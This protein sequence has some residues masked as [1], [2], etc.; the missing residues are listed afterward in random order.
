MSQVSDLDVSVDFMKKVAM[1]RC[2]SGSSSSSSGGDNE[3][4]VRYV[5][6]DCIIRHG[7]EDQITPYVQPDNYHAW[8]ENLWLSGAAVEN[9]R[10][11]WTLR[12]FNAQRA[13]DARHEARKLFAL[14]YDKWRIFSAN[15][16]AEQ[17]R[18]TFAV[19][20]WKPFVSTRIIYGACE[21]RNKQKAQRST[22]QRVATEPS[23]GESASLRWQ[24]GFCAHADCLSA[25]IESRGLCKNHYH[26][27]FNRVERPAKRRRKA[28]ARS[29]AKT[30]NVHLLQTQFGI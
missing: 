19:P 28:D 10:N 30:E 16:K 27:T 6:G 3:R 23:S 20:E 11:V 4:I 15:R 1:L 2:G 22:W 12:E 26:E 21:Q 9:A 29:R 5:N 7:Y 18:G 24:Y 25:L 13:E 8:Q 14:V 17:K